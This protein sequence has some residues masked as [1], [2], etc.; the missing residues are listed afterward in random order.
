MI[1]VIDYGM[2]NLCSVVNALK[3]LR[4][5]AIISRKPEDLEKSSHIIL[6]GVGAFGDGIRNLRGMGILPSLEREVL[7]KK[8]PLLGICLGMQ[9]L[10]ERGFEGGEF[11]GLGWVSGSVKKMETCG[12]KLPHMGWNDIGVVQRDPLFTGLGDD[13]NFYFVHSFHLDCPEEN[14]IAWC[15]YGQRF[16]AA[17]RKDNIFATQFHPEKSHLVG[18]IVLRN[19]INFRG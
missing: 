17:V 4:C 5:D 8:K 14:V 9:M 15:E 13:R 19:F 16:A 18:S 2:G 11:E 1:A 7:D 10:A 6:P 12:L 3:Y